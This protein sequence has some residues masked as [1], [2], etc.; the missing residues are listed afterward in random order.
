MQQV[1]LVGIALSVLLAVPPLHADEV[2]NLKA[3][4]QAMQQQMNAL[5]EQLQKVTE[6]LERQTPPQGFGGAPVLAAMPPKLRE[7]RGGRCVRRRRRR[8]W[9]F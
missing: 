3:Q 4:L 1:K 8:P 2:S 9:I 6:K 7:S 5:Q